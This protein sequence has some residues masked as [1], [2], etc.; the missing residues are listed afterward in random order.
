VWEIYPFWREFFWLNT[1]YKEVQTAGLGNVID[2]FIADLM[3]ADPSSNGA[4]NGDAGRES[5]IGIC[6]WEECRGDGCL[7]GLD[8][9]SVP[10]QSGEL[11]R[12][13]EV[14][15]DA[16][17][18]VEMRVAPTAPSTIGMKVVISYAGKGFIGILYS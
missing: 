4:I 14:V 18:R 2:G 6:A 9:Q 12:A 16:V 7:A 10:A 17:D 1:I 11:A 5:S 3:C 8:F 13:L 15:V